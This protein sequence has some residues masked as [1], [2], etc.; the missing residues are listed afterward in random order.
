MSAAGRK[1]G[2]TD[3]ATKA[4]ATRAH[5]QTAL[6]FLTWCCRQELC[7]RQQLCAAPHVVDNPRYNLAMFEGILAKMTVVSYVQ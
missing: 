3:T 4:P 6:A 5:K 1:A 2:S 7:C